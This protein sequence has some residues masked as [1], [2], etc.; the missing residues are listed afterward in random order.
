MKTLPRIIILII[1]IVNVFLV[2]KILLAGKN[3]QILN[4]QGI[5]AI[6]DRNIMFTAI[7]L[8]LLVVVPVFIW[9]FHV[10]TKYHENNKNAKYTPDWDSNIL[11]QTGI[12]AFPSLI[13]IILCFFNWKVAHLFDPHIAITAAKKP[14]TIE[15]V[16]TRWKWVFI[17]PEQN[18][19]TVNLVEFP[20]KTPITFVLTAYE[21]PMNSF[22]IPQLDGQIYAMSGMETQTHLLANGIGTYRGVDAE[23]NGSGFANMKFIAKSVSQNDFTNWVSTIKQASK[24]LSEDTFDKLA[25]PSQNNPISY[26]SSTQENLYYT[27]V[28]KYMYMPT[29]APGQ[30]YSTN[31]MQNIEGM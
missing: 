6:Q 5:I 7:S 12:W 1:L 13:I 4:P 16:A 30:N 27:I 9:A 20:Q 28:T 26:F 2:G 8:M 29:G 15:V 3:I 18:I 21:T 24:P 11:L 10:A 19:A 23:I 25:Q 14:I 31:A 17:Y 22:W